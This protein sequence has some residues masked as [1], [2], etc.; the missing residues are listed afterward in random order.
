VKRRTKAQIAREAGL[1]PLADALLADPTLKP[2]DEAAKFVNTPRT[3]GKAC[4]DIKAA[5]DGARQIL[6][7]R[8]AE[9]AACWKNCAVTCTRTASW[10]PRSW[11]A[12][13]PKAPSSATGSTSAKASRT[14]PRTAPWP[15]CAAATKDMLRLSL[16]TGPELQL[17]DPPR[18]SPCETM[19]ASHFGIKDQGR[20]AD[21]WLL[22][23]ARWPGWSS[24]RCTSNWN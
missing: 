17:E 11:M 3:T 14:C 21:R 15:C 16:K 7:E 24:S 22:E 23:T 10:S 4:A 19:V 13:R 9:D 12:R 8:F 5:L 2:E 20:A 18:N 6:M 1:E